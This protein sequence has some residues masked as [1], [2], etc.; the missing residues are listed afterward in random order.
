MTVAANAASPTPSIDPLAFARSVSEHGDAELREFMS[1]GM[2]RVVLDEIFRRMEEHFDADRADGTNAVI[3]WKI[4][5]LPKGEADRY[6][7]R[8]RDGS[9]EVSREMTEDPRVTF[10]VGPVDFLKL[11]TGNASGPSLFLRRKLR[12][13]GDL[14]FAARV[15]SLFRIPG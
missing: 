12:I 3:R 4:G 8:I 15:P 14:A 6:E 9:C 10:S 13:R 7:V 2:R 11:A 1:G 5:G